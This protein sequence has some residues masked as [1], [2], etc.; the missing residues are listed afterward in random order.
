MKKLKGEDSEQLGISIALMLGSNRQFLY[1]SI[2]V[3]KLL[4]NF[5]ISIQHKSH[6]S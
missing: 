4:E 3:K 6:R 1:C 5:R 2:S